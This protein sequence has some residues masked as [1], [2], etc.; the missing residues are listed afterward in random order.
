MTHVLW[1][2]LAKSGRTKKKEMVE[3]SE[4]DPNPWMIQWKKELIAYAAVGAFGG[5][6]K[7]KSPRFAASWI[8][9]NGS[10]CSQ[11]VFCVWNLFFPTFSVVLAMHCVFFSSFDDFIHLTMEIQLVE[12]WEKM[13][14]PAMNDHKHMNRERTNVN[15]TWMKTSHQK[16]VKWTVSLWT[17][18][19]HATKN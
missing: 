1:L 3:K 15:W 18:H 16:C 12:W 19:L 17:N 2:S 4:K 14:H 8:I 7:M 10:R 11:S 5:P 6:N 13:G 9:H